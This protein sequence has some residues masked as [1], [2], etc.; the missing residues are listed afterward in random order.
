MTSGGNSSPAQNNP[1]GTPNEIF[2]PSEQNPEQYENIPRTYTSVS[3]D[4]QI[5]QYQN[6]PD[7]I[8]NAASEEVK[9]E[10]VANVKQNGKSRN[11]QAK[12]ENIQNET[13]GDNE[14]EDDNVYISIDEKEVKN[15]E[16]LVDDTREVERDKTY[17]VLKSNN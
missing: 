15:Y 4:H 5:V 11:N 8:N 13:G 9:Y 14:D 10:D 7:V 2:G 12:Y 3:P 16:S 1:D 17:A 6:T